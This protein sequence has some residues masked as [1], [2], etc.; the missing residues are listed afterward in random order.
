MTIVSFNAQ[1]QGSP[2][3]GG[4]GMLPIDKLR[5]TNVFDRSQIVRS[6]RYW[7]KA[8]T[9]GGD[10]ARTA[11]VLMHLMRDRTYIISDVVAGRWSASKRERMIRQTGE[12]D[13]ANYPSN[14]EVGIEQEPGSGGKE[15]A[16]NTVRNMAGFNIFVDRVTSD[17]TTRADPF[18]AQ[19]QNGNVWLVA[20]EWVYDYRDEAEVFP[21]GGR[22]DIIDASSG[23]F[24]RIAL[25]NVYD[26]TYA[27]VDG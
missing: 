17:K 11:G 20:G 5:V 27:W 7:D 6:V 8:G 15:S 25:T 2:M 26:T 14:Y 1:Y 24:N 16:E 23:A 3:Q 12:L 22:K 4:G 18:A 19:V 9:E 13:R 21:D 10:G